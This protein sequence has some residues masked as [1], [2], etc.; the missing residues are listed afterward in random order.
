MVGDNRI[1]DLFGGLKAVP[2]TLNIDRQG[3][4]AATH[5]GLCKKSDYENDIKA[6]LNE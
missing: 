2:T 1:S 5:V 4:V 6:V 3:R